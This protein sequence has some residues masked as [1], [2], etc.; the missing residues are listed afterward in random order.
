MPCAIAQDACIHLKMVCHMCDTMSTA[1]EIS[2]LR[3]A[4][5]QCSPRGFHVRE[6]LDPAGGPLTPQRPWAPRRRQPGRRH[7]GSSA[8]AR[9]SGKI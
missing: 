4:A 1:Q 7:T 6:R 8:A 9:M 3:G 5:R 2:R